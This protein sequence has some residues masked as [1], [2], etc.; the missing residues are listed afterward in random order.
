[1]R[2][3][4]KKDDHEEVIR[5]TEQLDALG[6]DTDQKLQDIYK[7]LGDEGFYWDNNSWFEVHS[8]SD[9]DFFTDAIHELDNAVLNAIRL[10]QGKEPIWV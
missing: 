2:I 8:N 7:E 5:Y 1:M 4:Y 3:N 6:I 10:G 9:P